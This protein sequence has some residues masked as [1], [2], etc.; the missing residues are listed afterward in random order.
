MLIKTKFLGFEDEF[1]HQDSKLLTSIKE[2]SPLVEAT[3]EPDLIIHSTR[4]QKYHLDNYPKAIKILISSENYLPIDLE[5]NQ[6]FFNLLDKTFD[7]LGLHNSFTTKL[8]EIIENINFKLRQKTQVYQRIPFLNSPLKSRHPEFAKYMR[9]LSL[10]NLKKCYAIST[11]TSQ[12]PQIFSLPYFLHNLLD[13]YHLFVLPNKQVSLNN[14]KKFCAFIV[15]DGRSRGR[16]NFCRA[17]AKYKHIDYYGKA[18][19]NTKFPKQ[20]LNKYQ[21]SH[22][23]EN[24]RHAVLS[25]HHTN[26]MNQEL[27]QDYKFA[28]CFENSVADDYITEK[29]PNAI[30]SG[31][32]PIY[33]GAKNV[34]DFFNTKRF[35]NYHDYEY[36]QAMIDKVIELNQDDAKYQEML[37]QPI[38][39]NNTPPQRWVNAH[40]DLINFLDKTF[41]SL[42][43]E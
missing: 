4:I 7:I 42:N 19:H 12:S 29:L 2:R 9:R 34:G 16:I 41:A 14:N 22:N 8:L 43:F 27:F 20:L 17:L 39:K 23:I 18:L 38:F 32:I 30:L 1:G 28:I 15:N 10:G 36:Y 5:K 35:I 24:Q 21:H 13:E 25:M 26:Y 37:A 3:E 33:K 11:N 40:Y 6:L 31:S